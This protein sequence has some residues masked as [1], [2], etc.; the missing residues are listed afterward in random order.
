MFVR[1]ESPLFDRYA[2]LVV[3]GI[4]QVACEFQV[5]APDVVLNAVSEP[6]SVKERLALAV[7]D[8][9]PGV[10]IG[11]DTTLKANLDPGDPADANLVQPFFDVGVARPEA[12]HFAD[13]LLESR[14]V[15]F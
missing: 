1:K 6:P 5:S 12:L 2:V 8:R 4:Y 14:R 15:Y 11:V 10:A 9:G 7:V 3:V 13:E